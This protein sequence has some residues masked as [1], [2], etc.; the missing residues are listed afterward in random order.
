V[1]FLVERLIEASYSQGAEAAADAFAH[2]RL[3]A[4]DLPPGALATFFDRL[5]AEHGDAEG[6]VAHFL[7][8]PQLGDRIARAEAAGQ[9]R[10]PRAPRSTPR[11]GRPCAP[12][13]TDALP[14]REASAIA[15]RKRTETP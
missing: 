7:S 1:L 2:D 11:T 13:A 14:R 12:S 5:R 6:F 4:A 10:G 9:G 15:R 8:H 3:R